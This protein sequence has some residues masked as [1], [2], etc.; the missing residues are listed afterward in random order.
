M[1]NALLPALLAIAGGLAQADE[2]VTNVHGLD[3]RNTDPETAACDDFFQHANGSWLTRNPVPDAYSRWSVS[4]E[5]RERNFDLLKL[6]LEEAAADSSAPEGSNQKKIG[7]FFAS[8]MDLESINSQGIGPLRAD[9][10]RIDDIDNRDELAETVT[11]YHSEGLTLLFNTAVY[12]DLK[13]SSRYLVYSMQGGL[14]LP[15]RAYY[16]KDDADSEELRTAYRQHVSRMLQHTGMERS[17]ASAQ[18][19][20][21]LKLET[22]L[23]EASL[24]RLELRN[25]ENFYNVVGV[26]EADKST[27]NF[28]WS[29]Y[30][31]ELGLADLEDFSFAHPK[32]F[33]A[34]D[35]ELAKL[36]LVTWKAYLKW[37]LIN[38]EAPYLSD[39][40]VQAD[41]DFFSRKLRGAKELRPRWKRV[42]SQTNDTMGEALGELYVAKAFPPETKVRALEMIENL[43][44]ALKDRLTGLEWMGAET[45]QMALKKLST[46]R[47]KI[48]YPDE[49]RDYS[50][51]NVSRQSYVDNVREGDRFSCGH[52]AASLFRRGD[53]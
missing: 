6:I 4:N 31:N 24:S 2:Y 18:A 7:D 30:F 37:H 13:K 11:A 41:F 43:R 33:A 1:K 49:W 12:P 10:Q 42:L 46:F 25:L 20:A 14:G 9:L 5:V 16:L 29:R 47:A 15:E 50:K 17:D 32:F 52:H 23:A 19:E 48:G 53:R 27:P 35:G 36:P 21:I 34:M 3:S 40:I 44:A 38:A 28:P 51:L 45:K 22:R 8:A 39:E 26:K